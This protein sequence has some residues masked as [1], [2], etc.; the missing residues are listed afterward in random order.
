MVCEMS[1]YEFVNHKDN[2]DE[3]FTIN[4]QGTKYS[5]YRSTGPIS[6]SKEIIQERISKKTCDKLIAEYRMSKDWMELIPI[7]ENM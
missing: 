2:I 4:K 1:I 3:F 7:K 5:C 6:G